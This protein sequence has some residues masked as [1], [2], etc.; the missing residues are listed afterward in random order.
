MRRALSTERDVLR[1]QGSVFIGELV[2]GADKF[3][4]ACLQRCQIQRFVILY[5]HVSLV[6]FCSVI[7]PRAGG[8]DANIERPRRGVN[9]AS[10]GAQLC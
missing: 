6:V 9:S 2:N 7:D 5:S 3:V 8:I 10:D 4:D 1:F